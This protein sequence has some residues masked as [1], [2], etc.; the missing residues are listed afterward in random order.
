MT[1]GRVTKQQSCA[2]PERRRGWF[3]NPLQNSTSLLLNYIIISK[4]MPRTP[5]QV[6]ITV[7]LPSSLGFF[8]DLRMTFLSVHLK[9]N[10]NNVNVLTVLSTDTSSIFFSRALK[11]KK[12]LVFSVRALKNIYNFK[13]YMYYRYK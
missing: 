12:C 2:D 4:N 13:C 1:C 8:S 9:K 7:R 11:V 3:W 6:Q 5:W 10:R